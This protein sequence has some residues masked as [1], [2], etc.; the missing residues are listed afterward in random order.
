[1]FL[2]LGSTTVDLFITGMDH[3][4]AMGR[5]EFAQDNL[6]FTDKPLRMTIGGNGANSAYVLGRL[7]AGAGGGAGAV[8]LAS[9]V[10]AD[11]LGTIMRGWLDDAGVDTRALSTLADAGTSTTTIA[12][13]ADF[14]RASFHHA[15]AYAAFTAADM[16]PTWREETRFLLLTS[17]PLLTG[18]RRDYARILADAKAAGIT[19]AVDIGPAIGTPARVDEL[20]PLARHVDYLVTNEH[21]LSVCCRTED[22]ATARQQMHTA[23]FATVL[24]KLG[25]AGTL[26]SHAAGETTVPSIAVEPH[27]TVGAGD[28]F[29]AGLLMALSAGLGLEHAVRHANVTAALVVA[30]PHGVLGSPT[31]AEV[32]AAV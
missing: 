14:H 26:I 15:G 11:E 28:A 10:G 7:A 13:D 22:A 17:F 24:L 21:E 2:I 12:M 25:A 30:S 31:W 23:G 1:M 5:D 29:N 9:A 6:V 8:G 20:A 18:L 27:G 19:T 16:P 4:P 32:Q 3:L